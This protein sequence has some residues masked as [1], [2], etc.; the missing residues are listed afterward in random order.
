MTT[1]D[2][3]LNP[4][5]QAA[6]DRAEIGREDVSAVLEAAIGTEEY[7]TRLYPEFY[8][9]RLTKALLAAGLIEP[10]PDIIDPDPAVSS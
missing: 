3:T 8:V 1:A 7:A 10:Y 6:L 9:H 5:Q 2:R 4:T